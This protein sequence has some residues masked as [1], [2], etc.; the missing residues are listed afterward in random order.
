M[1]K[2]DLELVD[3][4]AGTLCVTYL[5]YLI[6]FHVFNMEKYA[7]YAVSVKYFLGSF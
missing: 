4:F 3:I 2:W 6:L 5:Q 7:K 1:V